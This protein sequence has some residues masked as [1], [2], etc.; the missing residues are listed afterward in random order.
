MDKE[1]IVSLNGGRG[2]CRWNYIDR[3]KVLVDFRGFCRGPCGEGIRYF[4]G[5][6][7][8][9]WEDS[10]DKNQKTKNTTII[11]SA[12]CS[13]T[14]SDLRSFKPNAILFHPSC[15]CSNSS[16]VALR[17]RLDRCRRYPICHRRRHQSQQ[18]CLSQCI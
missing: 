12:F 10:C 6:G 15:R 3:A 2:E 11:I 8:L 14:H 4:R 18:S 9:S 17:D 5:A 16:P 7:L 13:F 1:Q